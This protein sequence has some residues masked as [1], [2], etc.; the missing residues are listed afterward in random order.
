MLKKTI[1]KIG[2]N[3]EEILKDDARYFIAK[4]KFKNKKALFKIG[5]T[6]YTKDQL[7]SESLISKRI[8]QKYKNQFNPLY[9]KSGTTGKSYYFLREYIEGDTL[10]NVFGFDY[11]KTKKKD[12]EKIADIIKKTNKINISKL[13]R[14][15]FNWY[16]TDFINHRHDWTKNFNQNQIQKTLD[17]F[18]T[19]ANLINKN[20][21][22][23]HGD[24]FPHNII[25]IHPVRK[26]SNGAK[27]KIY[28]IDWGEATAT[29]KF[30]DVAT[31]WI[32]LWQK[33]IWQKTFIKKFITNKNSEIVAKFFIFYLSVRTLAIIKSCRHLEEN[34]PYTKEANQLIKFHQKTI[35][36]IIINKFEP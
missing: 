4:G 21:V 10:G 26:S 23:N 20:L 19:K 17:F 27:N 9:L 3:T 29:N 13:P 22:A 32:N 35:K 33:P 8:S 6:K 11:N 12:V 31:I 2:F 1:E 25:R 28:L 24:I 34:L 14:K 30:W 16:L 18:K 5:L 36:S 7:L 15:N